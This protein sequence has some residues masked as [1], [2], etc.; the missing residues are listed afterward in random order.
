MGQPKPIKT[1][2][3]AGFDGKF[4]DSQ[5][6]LLIELRGTYLE[7]AS[8]L[9]AEAD[10]IAAEMEPG[11][12]QFD[13]ESGEGGTVPIDREVDLMLSAQALQEV[14]EIDF[15]LAKIASKT[16]GFCEI[17]KQPIPKARLNAL[18]QARLCVDC[19]SGGL[20]RR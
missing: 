11:D 9:K 7:Q 4:Y 8:M 16:Y 2:E 14:E 10:A 5:K 15:A 1:A 3:E 12:I 19:K 13:E 6:E 17:C 20:A 18:P